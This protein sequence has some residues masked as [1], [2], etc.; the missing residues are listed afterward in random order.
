MVSWF[1]FMG[2]FVILFIYNVSLVIWLFLL[3]YFLEC[4]LMVC[5]RL[6]KNSMFWCF[7]VLI[8]LGILVLDSLGLFGCIIFFVFIGLFGLVCVCGWFNFGLSSS[9]VLLSSWL[10]LFWFFGVIWVMVII[11]CWYKI[12]LYL[13]LLVVIMFLIN[14]FILFMVSNIRL[15]MMLV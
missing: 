9:I 3:I 12:L 7:F 14:C 5:I 11:N 1:F 2:L 6:W 8:F 13:V 15:F 10:W 4:F